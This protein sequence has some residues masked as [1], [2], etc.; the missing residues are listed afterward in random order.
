MSSVHFAYSYF[1]YIY[2][3][4]HHRGAFIQKH[5][6]VVT[7]F[8]SRSRIHTSL[9]DFFSHMYILHS[10]SS[11][12]LQREQ[13]SFL[14]CSQLNIS[15]HANRRWKLFQIESWKTSGRGVGA[16]NLWTPPSLQTS[17]YWTERLNCKHLAINSLCQLTACDYGPC[18]AL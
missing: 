7:V 14:S 17:W 2:R 6:S 15:E 1:I 3:Q 4:A 9:Y 5:S 13:F 10:A 12:W 11:P 18:Q 8:L 16:H